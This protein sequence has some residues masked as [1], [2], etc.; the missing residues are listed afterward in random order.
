[1]TEQRAYKSI[2]FDLDGVIVRGSHTHP[3][4]YRDAAT[5]AVEELGVADCSDDDLDVL[6]HPVD[7]DGAVGR[8]RDLGIDP[9]EFWRL[10]EAAASRIENDQIRR[11]ERD[12]YDDVSTLSNLDATLGIV[13]NNRQQTVEFIIDWF[14][15]ERDFDVWL[16][17]D[18]TVGGFE[19]MKPDPHYIHRAL[20]SLDVAAE[21]TLYVGD[22][23]SDIVAARNAGTDAA[24]LLRTH[25]HEDSFSR[26]PTYVLSG[27]DELQEYENGTQK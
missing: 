21:R 5:R 25:N 9:E 1:M 2:V 22:R 16:G 13:S 26:E 19:R 14:S 8:C 4:V 17:R 27:L 6:G 7:V 10:R 12:L 18:E 23:E 11:G 20:N 15:L 3:S 24:Y